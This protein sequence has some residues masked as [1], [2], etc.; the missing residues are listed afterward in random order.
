MSSGVE[1][2]F[3]DASRLPPESRELVCHFGESEVC[4]GR[5]LLEHYYALIAYPSAVAAVS[6]HFFPD[7]FHAHLEHVRQGRRIERI[8]FFRRH[9]QV[10]RYLVA[11]KYL[12]VPVVDDPPCRVNGL[13]DHR[14]VGGVLLIAC[15]HDLDDKKPYDE[16]RGDGPQPNQQSVLSVK[17]HLVSP[18]M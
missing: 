5:Q 11:D 3:P 15:V 17:S 10:V 1:R 6:V 2:I 8:H 4:L 16:D 13:V 18:L 14:V 12:P 7:C 9:K